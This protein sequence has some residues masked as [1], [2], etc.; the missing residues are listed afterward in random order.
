MK[1]S[2]MLLCLTST[3][4]V[5]EVQPFHGALGVSSQIFSARGYDLVD[6]DDAFISFRLAGGTTFE[7][8]RWA[9]DV[10]GAFSTGGVTGVA[11]AQ[12]P[13][14]FTLNG[15]E[16]SATAR[17]PVLTWLA[18]YLRVGAGYDWATLTLFN[19]TRLTQTVGNIAGHAGLG[20]QLS[21][22]LTKAESRGVFLLGDLGVGGVLRPGYDFNAMA[23]EP[24]VGP[25]QDPLGPRGAVNVGTL[26]LSGLTLR[27]T[28]GLRF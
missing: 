4:A 9:L 18:P 17:W 7:L 5:A 21:A 19:T 1:T 12:I 3:A 14:S 20:V 26:P 27:A 23:P 25:Q 24:I 6:I 10:E 15:L 16:L 11:H 22:R 8:G 2:L 13:T 28:V